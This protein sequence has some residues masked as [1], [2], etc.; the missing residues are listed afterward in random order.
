M[1][2][3]IY[4]ALF[5][6]DNSGN[7]VP[8]LATG[9]HVSKDGLTYTIDLRPKVKFSDGTPF[10]SQ[11][12]A[13]NLDRDRNP[14]NASLGSTYVADIGSIGTPNATTVV[15]HMSE[16]YA[17]LIIALATSVDDFMVSPTAFNAAGSEAAYG[18]HPVGAG[19][20]I[21]Q[22]YS[23]NVSM[24]LT[25][26]PN[27]WNPREPYVT[28]INLTY[29]NNSTTGYDTVLAAGKNGATMDLG[30]ATT[31]QTAKQAKAAGGVQSLRPP[32][33]GEYFIHFNTYVA[34]FNNLKAREAVAYATSNVEVNKAVFLGLNRVVD[35]MGSPGSAFYPS[36]KLNS[37][38]SYDPTKARQ[39]VS[40][41]GGLSF[42]IMCVPCT[43]GYLTQA[44]ALQQLWAQ[45]GIQATVIN[46]SEPQAVARFTAGDFET[47]MSSWTSADPAIQL[48]NFVAPTGTLNHGQADPYLAIS[49]AVEAAR[50]RPCREARG[51]VRPGLQLHQQDRVQLA[52]GHHL[53][54]QHRVGGRRGYGQKSEHLLRAVLALAIALTI[55]RRQVSGATR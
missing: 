44:D 16:P 27:Y 26:N 36:R 32:A 21:V 5:E 51:V 23:P 47:T 34:P 14:S 30:G 35:A 15:L 11:A 2:E 3:A 29:L 8:D 22:S 40:E 4:G 31:P 20:F 18:L 33:T 7:P 24:S 38:L 28:S 13:F 10:N 37:Y 17:P 52:N 45:V 25:R 6:T 12:V 42:T 54:L 43:Y 50:R 41:I 1:F 19:P 46:L 9:Y 39:L 53:R 49:R 48:G 55:P